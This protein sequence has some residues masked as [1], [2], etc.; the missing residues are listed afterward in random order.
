M[1]VIVLETSEE[2]SAAFAA[3]RP[4]HD[5]EVQEVTG[6][7]HL[8]EQQK[9][10]DQN[11]VKVC[12]RTAC[13]N[14]APGHKGSCKLDTPAKAAAR[15]A[16]EAKKAA[17]E[18]GEVAGSAAG[19]GATEQRR[20][21][22]RG[23]VD[24]VKVAAGRRRGSIEEPDAP[25]LLNGRF[26]VDKFNGHITCT[27]GKVQYLSKSGR[28]KFMHEHECRSKK[29]EPLPK[30]PAE[31]RRVV[32]AETKVKCE[33]KSSAA[34]KQPTASLGDREGDDA[35]GAAR[36]STAAEE[37]A[38]LAGKAAGGERTSGWAQ[39][40]QG[41]PLSPQ[42]TV[43]V[44]G[45]VL[46]RVTSTSEVTMVAMP[47]TAPVVEE[48]ATHSFDMPA[49]DAGVAPRPAEKS[50]FCLELV[51]KP[52]AD[53][54]APFA[55]EEEEVPA[56]TGSGKL[57]QLSAQLFSATANSRSLPSV[58]TAIHVQVLIQYCLRLGWGN[59]PQ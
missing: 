30:P 22:Q 49:G 28:E 7:A 42:P 20:G 1:D 18:A 47:S 50:V 25:Q 53:A 24:E 55:A 2:E 51:S 23:S 6:R 27:C 17:A 40:M 21:G 31:Q 35:H 34:D 54:T 48:D 36:K 26:T 14:K 3:P 46:D 5:R 37:A 44:G 39:A 4:A 12:Q 32:A 52:A 11:H 9:P 59:L 57:L 29:K 19:A 56:P 43:S 13:C 38:A 45:A 33:A 41:G 10:D 16:R 58:V 15:A 8:D